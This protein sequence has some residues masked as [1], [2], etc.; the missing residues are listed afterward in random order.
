MEATAFA[1]Q[2]IGI[3]K[4]MFDNSFNTVAVMQ[5]QAETMLQTV[6]GQLPWVTEEGKKQMDDTLSLNKKARDDF[7]KAIEEGYTRF[8][9]LF[10][11]K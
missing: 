1:K 6:M 7:K 2:M 3:Q 11:Q 8:E 5:D 9:N 4:T 10:D